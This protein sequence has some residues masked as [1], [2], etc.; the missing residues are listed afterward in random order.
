M[1]YFF[2]RLFRPVRMLCLWVAGLSHVERKVGQY[3]N[4][5]D[6][7][8][9]QLNAIRKE[10]AQTSQVLRSD[11]RG[12]EMAHGVFVRQLMTTLRS[13]EEIKPLWV[14]QELRDMVRERLNGRT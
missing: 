11:I 5:I 14:A 13:A 3:T 8:S 2:K 9:E 10:F 1:K 6:M 12:Q 4:H 7:L